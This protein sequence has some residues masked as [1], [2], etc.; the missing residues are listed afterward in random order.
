GGF[1]PVAHIKSSPGRASSV[2]WAGAI[3]KGRVYCNA[4]HGPIAVS[5]Q[6]VP[7]LAATETRAR[8]RG[9]KARSGEKKSISADSGRAAAERPRAGGCG[10]WVK[11]TWGASGASP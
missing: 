5:E 9:K 8:A 1:Y 11:W 4:A 3:D 6:W 2:W 10:K 7:D